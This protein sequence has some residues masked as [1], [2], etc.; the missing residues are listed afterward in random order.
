MRL[1]FL[2]GAG[3]SIPVLGVGTT[4]LTGQ[5][6]TG[7]GVYRASDGRYYVGGPPAGSDALVPVEKVT[8]LLGIIRPDIQAFLDNQYG[9]VAA[10]NYEDLYYTCD[11]VASMLSGELENP[12][13]A[14]YARRLERDANRFRM[15]AGPS[16]DDQAAVSTATREACRYIRDVVAARLGGE[17]DPATVRRSHRLLLDALADENPQIDI[18]TLNHDVVLEQL[19]RDS[20]HEFEDGFR[21]HLDG[22]RKWSGSVLLQPAPL[23]LFKVHGSIDWFRFRSGP[24]AWWDDWLGQ[25]RRGVDPDRVSLGSGKLLDCL[26]GPEFLLGS[27]NKIMDYTRTGF[28]DLFS[29]AWL[30]LRDSAVLIVSGYSFSDKG[31]NARV[32]DWMYSAPLGTRRLVVIHP[33]PDRLAGGARGAIR[34]KWEGWRRQ[35]VL[36]V[37][38]AKLEDASWGQ[39]RRALD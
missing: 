34:E 36:R 6:V 7:S 17:A 35:G 26:D 11:Q 1:C 25:V 8:A 28:L 22:V 21:G 33:D 9:R 30:A 15:P 29:A 2:L 3:T 5:V 16:Q 19:F 14:E 38:V 10:V 12:L 13:V 24:L 27:F 39:V 20:G 31:I 37:V 32:T 4:D 18:I 23:R